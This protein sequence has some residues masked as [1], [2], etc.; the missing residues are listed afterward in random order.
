[1]RCAMY[2]RVSL[3]D[4]AMARR[5]SPPSNA[6]SIPDAPA[7]LG[8][9]EPRLRRGSGSRARRASSLAHGR[10]HHISTPGRSFRKIIAM[11]AAAPWVPGRHIAVIPAIAVRECPHVAASH[12]AA[13]DYPS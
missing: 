13:G 6:L 9:A 2:A 4:R 10:L 8:H 1:M 11:H 5:G 7:K 12:R 3:R